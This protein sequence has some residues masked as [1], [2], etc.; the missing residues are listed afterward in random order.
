MTA[1]RLFSRSLRTYLL[2][3]APVTHTTKPTFAGFASSREMPF[4]MPSW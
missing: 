4:F 2:V 1:V 3:L